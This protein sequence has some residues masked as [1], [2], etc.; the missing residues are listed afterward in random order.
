MKTKMKTKAPKKSVK[1][2]KKI[3]TK[4]AV[5]KTIKAIEKK[6]NSKR[7]TG[8]FNSTV[9]HS[10]FKVQDIKFSVNNLSLGMIIEIWEELGGFIERQIE[11]EIKIEEGLK[12]KATKNKP[13][14][15]KK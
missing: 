4:K 3:A 13:N 5:K 8:F 10:N 7:Q 9:T 2:V 11:I 12:K 1:S 15:K 14:T 6:V